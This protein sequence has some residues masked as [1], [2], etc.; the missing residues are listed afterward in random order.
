[1]VDDGDPRQ[2]ELTRRSSSYT[3][4]TKNS[5]FWLCC[6]SLHNAKCIVGD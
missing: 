3:I 2:L 4:T 5:C 6:C 1:M